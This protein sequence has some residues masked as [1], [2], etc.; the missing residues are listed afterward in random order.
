MQAF[1]LVAS[2][3]I[4]S[5]CAGENRF[6]LAASV[7]ELGPEVS[8]TAPLEGATLAPGDSVQIDADLN[9]PSGVASVAYSGTY[10]PSGE[11]AYTA[12]TEPL[13]G[14]TTANV[15]NYLTAVD[16]QVEGSVYL[17]VEVTDAIGETARDSV[18]VTIVS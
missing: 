13:G 16:G 10:T 5:A 2:A 3:A 8:I 17:V 7:S 6:S 15:S 14:G 18:K 1:G 12:E 4:L 11:D 9:A